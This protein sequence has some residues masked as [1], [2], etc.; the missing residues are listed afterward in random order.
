MKYKDYRLLTSDQQK[1]WEFKFKD[2]PS[3]VGATKI[4]YNALGIIVAFMVVAYVNITSGVTDAIPIMNEFIVLGMKISN[5][6]CWVALISYI[7]T[8]V[9]YFMRLSKEHKFLKQCKMKNRVMVK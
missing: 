7:L 9:S 8:V 2:K 1:E 4:L 3:I 5:I 6:I